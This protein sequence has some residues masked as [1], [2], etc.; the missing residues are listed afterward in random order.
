ML[1]LAALSGGIAVP[2]STAGAAMAR[3]HTLTEV[4]SDKPELDSTVRNTKAR[5]S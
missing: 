1:G 3:F 5:R 4:T 2:P